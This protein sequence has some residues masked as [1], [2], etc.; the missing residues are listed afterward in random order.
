MKPLSE[1]LIQLIDIAECVMCRSAQQNVR[2]LPPGFA[3]SAAEIRRVHALPAEATRTTR[4]GIVM[5]EAIEGFAA[6]GRD[7]HWQMLIGATLPI[8]R[9]EAYVAFLNEKELRS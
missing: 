7:Y 3:A 8:L 2:A 1:H 9:R 6:N 4:A 5:C